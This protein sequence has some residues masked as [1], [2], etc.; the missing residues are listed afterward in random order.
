MCMCIFPKKFKINLVF[1]FVLGRV[2]V[3]DIFYD[4][5]G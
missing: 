5:L 4:V 3:T 1:C 2:K